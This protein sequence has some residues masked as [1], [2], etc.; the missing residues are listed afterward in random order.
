[1]AEHADITAAPRR[2]Q[3]DGATVLGLCGALALLS[4][5]IA[6]GGSPGA[7]IDIPAILIVLGGTL[8][9]T[10]ICF[11]FTDVA[12]TFGVIGST[13]IHRERNARDVAYTMLELADYSRRHGVLGLGGSNLVRFESDPFLHKA[14]TLVIEGLPE[15]DIAEILDEDQAASTAR[16]YR[17]AGVL[18]KA[19]EIAPAMGLI[20]TLIGLVHML[21]NLNDP[22]AIGPAMAIALLATFYGAVLANVVLNPLAS[23]FERNAAEDHLIQHLQALGVLSVVRKENPRRL[24]MLL[25]SALPPEAKVRFFE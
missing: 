1:M 17:S 22:K 6:L 10:T 21:G 13:V 19:A 12:H 23:K 18:R 15:K 24:E 4:I 2:I 9:V 8:A 5:A 7:F 20:A 14:L 3:F 16:V 25:N 11:N